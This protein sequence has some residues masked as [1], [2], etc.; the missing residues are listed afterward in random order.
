VQVNPNS[1]SADVLLLVV[2]ACHPPFLRTCS[3]A[4][5]LSVPPLSL[6]SSSAL[7]LSLPPHS[8][9][10]SAVI[11]CLQR[12][13]ALLEQPAMRLASRASPATVTISVV[14]LC[15]Q[16]RVQGGD[17][18]YQQPLLAAVPYCCCELFQAQ[19]F[20]PRTYF[21]SCL[22]FQ[23]PFLRPCSSATALSLPPYLSTPSANVLLP[24]LC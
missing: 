8:S 13:N 12:F 11:P 20:F 21:V 2:L 14:A 5:A 18:L 6:A 17:Q 7:A 24:S 15:H 9:A 1:F 10:L 23:P 22:G 3:F 4:P 16:Q 19:L